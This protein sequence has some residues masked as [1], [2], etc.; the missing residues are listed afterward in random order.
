MSNVRS[1]SYDSA[2]FTLATGQTNYDVRTN[3]ATAFDNVKNSTRTLIR[4]NI[5]IGVRI[6][7]ATKPLIT[8]GPEDSPLEIDWQETKN[9][10]ITNSSGSTAS[11]KIILVE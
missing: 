11:I 10:F 3:V 7:S 4:T 9:L 6:N 5:T 8:V 1:S 2:E